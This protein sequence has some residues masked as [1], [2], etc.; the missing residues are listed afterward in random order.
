MIGAVE[1]TARQRGDVLVGRAHV[2][3]PLHLHH[4]AGRIVRQLVA[5]IERDIVSL[6]VHT[7]DDQIAA[8]AQLVG[9]PLRGHAADDR[10]AVITRLEHRQFARR[11][12]HGPL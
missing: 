12:A 8:V 9:Q 6:A 7:V 1:A 11:A 10:A 5:S 4:G 3:R 2:G